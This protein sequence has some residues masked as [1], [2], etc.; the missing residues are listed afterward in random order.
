M[1]TSRP[2]RS[3]PRHG[4]HNLHTSQCLYHYFMCDML[5][6]VSP[7]TGIYKIAKVSRREPPSETNEVTHERIH[8]SVM[9]Q[10]NLSPHVRSIVDSNPSIL[11]GLLPWECKVKGV[12]D[13]KLQSESFRPQ[14]LAK[15]FD[16]SHNH[17]DH[18]S[19]IIHKAVD[20]IKHLKDGDDAVDTGDSH[21]RRV[22]SAWLQSSI[23]PV[24]QE[25]L[26]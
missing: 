20:K 12:W 16:S 25:L 14:A 22:L 11:H 24:V 13:A 18:S 7:L 4:G 26:K 1:T 17:H 21:H 15:H 3:R 6:I 9:A 8:P 2:S 23:G 10:P 5:N 19:S